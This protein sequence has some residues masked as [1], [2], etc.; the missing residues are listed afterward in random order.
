[1]AGWAAE[2]TVSTEELV[3]SNAPTGSFRLDIALG[4]YFTLL[5]KDQTH[6][7]PRCHPY[8]SQ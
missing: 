1:M 4:P 8:S 6:Y 5:V 7:P 3:A 2:G